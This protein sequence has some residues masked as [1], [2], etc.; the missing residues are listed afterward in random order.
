[1][2]RRMRDFSVLLVGFQ[3][4][5]NLGLRYLTAAVR[6]AGFR[7]EIMTYTAEPQPLLD[8]VARTRPDVIGF[9]LIFQYMAPDFGRVIAALREQGVPAHITIGGHYPSF[10][11]AE[12]LRRIPG[13]DS[14]VRFEGEATLVE[15]MQKLH[16]GEDWRGIKGIAFRRDDEPVSNPLRPPI[17]D[18]DTLPWPER[19]DIDYRAKDLSTAS[20]LAS[21]GCPWNCNFCSIRPFYEA[22]GGA[23]RRLRD[24]DAVVAE[25]A[26]LHFER[27]ARIFLFQD[28]DFLATGARARD[29]ADSIA[30]GLVA[31]GLAGKIA[32]KISCRSDEIRA[33]TIRRLMAA[34]LTHIYMGV[35]NGD[36]Q[37]LKHMNKMITPGQ[38][39]KAGETLKELGL[40]FDFGFMLLEP[41]STTD[42]VRTNI[43][44]LDRFVGDGWAVAS[45]C[46]TL[47][48]AGTPLKRRLEAEGRML[49]TSFEPDYRFLDPKLDL[50]YEWLL[51]TFYERNFTNRGLCHILRAL[52][53]EAR[54]TLPGYRNFGTA[55]RD[56][57]HHLTARCNGY[58]LYT[59]R[60]ALDHIEATP[61]EALDAEDRRLAQLTF[62][63]QREE[64]RL[65][66]Q[67][68]EFYWD[69][70]ERYG[71]ATPESRELETLGSFENSWTLADS[72]DR[73][74]AE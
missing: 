32:F 58:A 28:D 38:H 59:L 47:P 39:L 17:E 67:V 44:F 23:L 30:R 66:S 41:Y 11:F 21:R 61:L 31:T 54:L 62:A 71:I 14:V 10:D 26:E 34:G 72:M 4:Q 8:L 45:F 51:R 63:E 68:V 1:M 29:W 60:A 27:G 25:L 19:S 64:Q 53:F 65:M 16:D 22:Q 24:P 13:I 37:G 40:S 43:E 2:A 74:A 33:D 46:R 35:E 18:L 36:E 15:L 69:V 6:R 7:A 56:Y 5:D 20:V 70:R 57:L 49:G 55:D 12:V 50:F 48:Y 3:D 52:L 9:S 73:P 42:T